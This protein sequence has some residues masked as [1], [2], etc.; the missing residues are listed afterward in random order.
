MAAAAMAPAFQTLWF[1]FTS[2][3]A[4]LRLVIHKAAVVWV[5]T[6]PPPNPHHSCSCQQFKIRPPGG[7]GG[8]NASP[9]LPD[10]GS[11]SQSGRH[12]GPGSG[13]PVESFLQPEGCCGCSRSWRDAGV[14]HRR[15][16]V[17]CTCSASPLRPSI[18]RVRF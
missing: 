1:I 13:L 5:Q 18:E 4:S 8:F 7:G 9:R 17:V 14:Q 16:A 3:C 12:V 2:F 10:S 6:L 15:S 11:P